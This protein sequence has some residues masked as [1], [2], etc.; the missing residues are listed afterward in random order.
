M[1]ARAPS[2]R[3]KL[4]GKHRNAAGPEQQHRV[5]GLDAGRFNQRVPCRQRG[6]G[7][8]CRLLERQML[9][10]RHHTVGIE[11]G[12]L[13]QNAVKSTAKGARHRIGG[14]LTIGPSLKEGRRTRGPPCQASYPGPTAKTSPARI[15]VGNARIGK[16]ARL[17]VPHGAEIPEVDGGCPDLAPSPRPDLGSG[18]AARQ[19]RASM[20]FGK[21]SARHAC[22]LQEFCHRTD[23]HDSLR[24]GVT[25]LKLRAVLRGRRAGGSA[26]LLCPAPRIH[27]TAGSSVLRTALRGRE[28]AQLALAWPDRRVRQIIP[29]R[30]RF[31]G[32][33]FRLGEIGVHADAHG[34]RAHALRPLHEQYVVD[35]HQRGL[36][37][38]HGTSPMSVAAK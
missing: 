20:P 30:C 27:R 38:Q 36:H 1:M 5:A 23:R 3:R 35:T 28:L 17:R 7:Q 19:F 16:L 8:S 13:G 12:L 2:S 15:R 25:K 6:A 24:H 34:H 18:N 37:R 31:Q 32:R 21:R 11:N 29:C 10:D 33:E 22:G 9:R 4:Q 14:A 26:W